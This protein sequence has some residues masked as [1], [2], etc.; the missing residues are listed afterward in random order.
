MPIR[1][2]NGM[3]NKPSLLSPVSR[4]T[5]RSKL[6]IQGSP[7]FYGYDLWNAYEF[8]WLD[9]KGQPISAIAQF[10]IP[11]HSPNL[12]EAESFALYLN[13]FH[14]ASFNHRDEVIQTL[15]KDLSECVQSPV[16]LDFALVTEI[17]Y[18]ELGRLTGICLDLLDVEVDTYVVKPDL[19][20]NSEELIEET[21][22]SDLF[23][24][25]CQRTGQPIWGSLQI[26]YK[27]HKIVHEQLLKYLISFRQDTD[28][29]ENCIERIFID[30]LYRCKPNEL[31]VT[32]RFLRRAGMDNNPS[33]STD[34]NIP[35]DSARCF[36]Q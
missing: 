8:S 14:Q 34:P 10:L 26:S 31:T 32:G 13:S 4:N 9:K 7:P 36:R 27:G 2:D 5:F 30:I 25:N 24:T 1:H 16:L 23:K 12:I 29:N 15:T 6:G 19:L 20:T 22:Y 11:S 28:F 35:V 33:R 17:S 18:C 3:A 21:V